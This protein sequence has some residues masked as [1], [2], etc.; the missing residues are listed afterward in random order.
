MLLRGLWLVIVAGDDDKRGKRIAPMLFFRNTFHCV[1]S[2]S[3]RVQYVFG[4]VPG[5]CNFQNEGKEL[6]TAQRGRQPVAQ[7][8]NSLS[9]DFDPR[10]SRSVQQSS[11]YRGPLS[12]LPQDVRATSSKG[13]TPAVLLE[14]IFH[15]GMVVAQP[16]YHR[17]KGLGK[18][19]QACHRS[20]DFDETPT[21]A[22]SLA[23]TTNRY[24]FC[25][26][27]L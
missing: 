20:D 1:Y 24:N 17:Y 18:G 11:E 10:G 26:V 6:S 4:G 14:I 16:S 3:T 8:R 22:A 13:P 7:Y 5:H 27:S 2:P 21:T 12:N 25:G 19:E 9:L 23:N 15:D